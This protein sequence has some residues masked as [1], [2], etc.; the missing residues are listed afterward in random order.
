MAVDPLPPP[1]PQPPPTP[2]PPSIADTSGRIRDG[3][4]MQLNAGLGYYK[5]STELLGTEATYSGT[6][7]AT[8]LLLGGALMDNLAIGGGI[9]LDRAGSPNQEVNGEKVES[10]V[11]ITQYVFALTGFVDYYLPMIEGL[12]VQALVGWGGLETAVEGNAGGSDPV[13]LLYGIGCGY[14]IGLS[15]SWSVGVLARLAYGS[16]KMVDGPK[17]GTWAPALAASLTYF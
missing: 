5:S 11:S 15:E 3:F 6:T 17:F 14:E 1:D 8:S 10:A 13:G 16:F 4:F 2:E 12:H 9:V 7:I